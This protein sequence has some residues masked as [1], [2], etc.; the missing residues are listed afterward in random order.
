MDRGEDGTQRTRRPVTLWRV[1]VPVV[2]LGAGALFATSAQTARGT[3]LRSPET[4]DLAGTVRSATGTVASLDAAVRVLTAQ[5]D[6]AAAAAGKG[7]GR[8]TAVQSQVE[9]LGDP[10]GQTPATGDGLTVTLDDAPASAVDQVDPT[11]QAALDQ[12]VIHQSDLQAVVNALWAG[13]AQ[14][15][16]IVGQRLVP[17]SAVRCVGNTLLLN[18]RV[19]SPPYAVE[20]IGP[21]DTMRTRLANS[22]GV[23]LLEQAVQAYGVGYEVSDP[24]TV[25]VPAYD[26]PLDLSYAAPG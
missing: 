25:T 11:D 16:S 12:L 2:A 5:V 6:A 26:G 10:F 20:A 1:L 4:V 9:A 23:S 21:P 3:D 17:T 8:V 24:H 22:Y 7:N 14:A 18:G 15:I 19:Y 13:G